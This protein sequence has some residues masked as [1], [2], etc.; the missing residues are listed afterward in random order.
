MHKSEPNP[1]DKNK[2]GKKEKKEDRMGY[3]SKS[4]GQ[5]KDKR[6]VWAGQY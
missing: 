4:D 5:K 6:I 3:L 2:K 1:Q